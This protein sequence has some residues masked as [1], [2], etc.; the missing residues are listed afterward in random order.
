MANLTTGLARKE[1]QHLLAPKLLAD[2]D[3]AGRARSVHLKHVLGQIQADGANLS[4]GRLPPV[5]L[6]NTTLARRCRRGASTP[7]TPW[8]VPRKRLRCVRGSQWAKCR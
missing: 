3:G 5:V 7:S 8:Q 6:N 1:G 2:D 4:H